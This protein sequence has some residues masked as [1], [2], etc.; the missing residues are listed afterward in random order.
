MGKND[1]G[2]ASLEK[3]HDNYHERF[4]RASEGSGSV[5]LDNRQCLQPDFR[6]PPPRRQ[7]SVETVIAVLIQVQ[8]L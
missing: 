8:R 1:L 4:A 3:E 2:S 7:F 6:R 5:N